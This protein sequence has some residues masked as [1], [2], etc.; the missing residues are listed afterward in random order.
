MNDNELIKLIGERYASASFSFGKMRLP[1]HEEEMNA[2]KKILDR[3]LDIKGR[4]IEQQKDILTD[5]TEEE[6]IDLKKKN[7]GVIQEVTNN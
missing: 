7:P 4:Q 3:L 1:E 6:L 5:I 2:Y